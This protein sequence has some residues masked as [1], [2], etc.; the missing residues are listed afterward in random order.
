MKKTAH[1]AAVAAITSALLLTGPLPCTRAGDTDSQHRLLPPDAG[2]AAR[3]KH[4]TLDDAIEVALRRN[5]DILRQ[6]QEIQRN[7]GVYVEVRSQALPHLTL[8]GTYT[9]DDPRLLENRSGTNG[10]NTVNVPLLRTVDGVTGADNGAVDISPLINA[11]LGNSTA[12]GAGG[13]AGT[14]GTGSGSF[15][16]PDKNYEIT[17]QVTQAVYAPAVPAA[18]RQARFTRDNSYYQL[19]ETVDTTVNNVKTQFYGVLLDQALIT[20]QEESIRLLESQL[21]DQQNRF[22]AGTVPRFDVLQAEVALSNQKPQLITAR[23][24]FRLAYIGLARSL[25][26][27]YGPDQERSSPIVV[28]GN[29]DYH[30]QDFSPEQSVLAAKANRALLKQQRQNILIEV[31]AVRIAAAGYQPT[32]TANAGLELRNSELERNLS[33]TIDGWFFG[34]SVNWN[35]FDGLATY[36]RVKQAKATLVEAKVTYDDAVRQ[37][38]QEVESNYLTLQQ[39]KELISSQTLNVS[40]AE[41][42]VRLSQARLSAG[43]GTQLDVLQSQVALTQAQTTELQ[44]RYDYATALANFERV[45]ATSTVYEETFDDPMVAKA[46]AGLPSAQTGA[47]EKGRKLPN[48]TVKTPGADRNGNGRP[49]KVK[50]NASTPKDPEYE[51]QAARDEGRAPRAPKPKQ[52]KPVPAGLPTGATGD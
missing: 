12:G 17:L 8:G 27:E 10:N 38:V 43:A 39:S 22:S 45:T 52:S 36:G 20:I 14:A 37:V 34:G 15:Q 32:I 19:R 3:L 30:P 2:L 26:V 6:L 5:P 51:Q 11:L 47:A 42:A 21:R 35:I 31:E 24:N 33:S 4:L 16:T 7:K 13:V 50:I 40:E 44:A 25:G 46:R 29:L 28:V 23:N 18:I 41:E 9:Q 48:S 1:R 49:V